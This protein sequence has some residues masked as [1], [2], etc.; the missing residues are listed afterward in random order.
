MAIKRLNSIEL[1]KE[2]ESGEGDRGTYMARW[3]Q[4]DGG[5]GKWEL[6]RV[7]QEY[8]PTSMTHVFGQFSISQ[9]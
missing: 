1:Y 2:K 5:T 7:Q 3:K 8:G 6:E 9:P 4:M